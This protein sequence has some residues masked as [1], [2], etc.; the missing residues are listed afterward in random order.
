MA[1]RLKRDESIAQGLRRVARKALKLAVEQLRTEPPPDAAIHEARKSVKKARAVLRLIE[2]D[3]GRGLAGSRKRLRTVNRA[4]SRLRDA[5]VM[6]EVLATLNRKNPRLFSEH[7]FARLQAQLKAH[8]EDATRT[9]V[10]DGSLSVAARE[11]RKLRRAAKRWK[12]AH[13][14]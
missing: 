3:R 10:A 7:T 9:A 8:K 14:R 12:P 13:R 2:A 5:D 1:Y 6:K 4:L 11:L